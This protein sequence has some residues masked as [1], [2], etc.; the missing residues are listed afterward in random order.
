MCGCGAFVRLL[1]VEN[2]DEMLEEG[3]SLV[4]AI[5]QM[6]HKYKE[7]RNCKAYGLV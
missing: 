5:T 7:N 2:W 4:G 6:L 1:S 3:N